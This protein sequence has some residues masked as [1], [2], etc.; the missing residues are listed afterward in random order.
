MKM[1]TEKNRDGHI[2]E[3]KVKVGFENKMDNDLDEDQEYLE[4]SE[5]KIKFM[6]DQIS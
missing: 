4:K 3:Y 2:I 6:F 5:M 1:K